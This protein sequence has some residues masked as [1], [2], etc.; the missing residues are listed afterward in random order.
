MPRVARLPLLAASSLLVA[1][2]F[3][4]CGGSGDGAEHDSSSSAAASSSSARNS[5]V[6][7]PDTRC[8]DYLEMGQEDQVRVI[9]QTSRELDD[10]F[11]SS[12]QALSAVETIEH[13]C[14]SDELKDGTMRD[15]VK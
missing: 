10:E 7:G 12:A 3:A 13:S 4:A 8:S 9:Q 2:S 11:V 14:K 15:F 6:K 1:T 5:L